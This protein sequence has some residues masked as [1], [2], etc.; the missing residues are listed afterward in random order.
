[1]FEMLASFHNKILI[2][3]RQVHLFE[4]KLLTLLA[5]T[6]LFSSLAVGSVGASGFE[7]VAP[8][9]GDVLLNPTESNNYKVLT[10]EEFIQR[11][12]EL[13]G[14]SV[15]EIRKAESEG[16]NTIY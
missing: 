3:E 4:K 13:T 16:R 11:K 6:S 7:E 9:A 10:E 1:M 8:Q 15:S 5:I 14:K 12:A 2:L